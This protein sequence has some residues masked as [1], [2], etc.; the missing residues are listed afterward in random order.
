MNLRQIEVFRAVMLAGSVTGA[1]RLLHVS[2]PGI[3]RMLGH[4]ELQ[5]GLQLFGRSRGKLRPTAEAQVLYAQV[6]QVYQGV[7]RIDDCA[8]ALKTGQQLKLRVLASP[9]T[10]LA[11][12][13]EAVARLARQYP[14]AHIYLETLLLRDIVQQLERQEADLAISTLAVDH[15]PLVATRIGR[16]SL[17]CVFPAGH[18]F[19]AM[20]SVKID[21]VM[22]EPLIMFSEDT[23]Q[24]RVILD[25]CAARGVRPLSQ[26]EVRAGQVA[27]ALVASGAGIAVVDELTARAWRSD[28]L[29]F[30]PLHRAPQFDVFAVHNSHM[31][32]SALALALTSHVAKALDASSPVPGGRAARR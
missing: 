6:Q 20:A 17:A 12:V 30:R 26:I 5:L 32:Q 7:Q 23:P 3:S 15:D 1:A 10:G 29:H 9:S 27:C 31:P 19:A 28:A 13:P 21:E 14:S 16:W 22:K 4:I 18:P 8:R 24:G 11:L 25:W 2:Q